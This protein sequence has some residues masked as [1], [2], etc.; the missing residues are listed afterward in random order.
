MII[1]KKLDLKPLINGC[2]SMLSQRS[3]TFSHE[4]VAYK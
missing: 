2:L 4:N 3:S 1:E